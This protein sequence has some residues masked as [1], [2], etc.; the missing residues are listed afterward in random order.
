MGK[1]VIYIQL[2]IQDQ[3]FNI[4]WTENIHDNKFQQLFSFHKVV[5]VNNLNDRVML[6]EK[7]MHIVLFVCKTP[8]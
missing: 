6:H 8:Q 3:I 1:Y 2:L 7:S 4:R 5:Q